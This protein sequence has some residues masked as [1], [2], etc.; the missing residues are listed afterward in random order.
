MTASDR[1]GLVPQPTEGLGQVALGDRHPLEQV[2]RGLA[3]L[4]ADDDHR[5]R[6]TASG[7]CL[8]HLVVSLGHS[9][10]RIDGTGRRPPCKRRRD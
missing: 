1:F 8:V 3:L 9:L 7:C 2:E 10:A 4:E 5:H 6:A